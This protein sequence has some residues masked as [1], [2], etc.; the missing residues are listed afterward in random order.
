MTENEMLQ[1]ICDILNENI[2][3]KI[4][5]RIIRIFK[6][7]MYKVFD[8]EDAPLN[9]RT[10]S[11][12]IS[13]IIASKLKYTYHLYCNV[14]VDSIKLKYY[15]NSIHN[16][17]YRIQ[18]NYINSERIFS[19]ELLNFAFISNHSKNHSCLNTL[20]HKLL[21]DYIIKGFD[22]NHY[23]C[24]TNNIIQSEKESFKLL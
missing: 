3:H 10:L 5:K 15:Y 9:V 19:S 11:V 13:A 20:S 12:F 22:E 17:G 4:A 1:K 6:N 14:D 8:K 24:D 23:S 16:Y 18:Y 21:T 2:E 7:Y